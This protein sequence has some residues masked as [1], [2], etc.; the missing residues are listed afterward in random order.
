MAS[1]LTSEIFTN[2]K[3]FSKLFTTS[4]VVKLLSRIKGAETI[5]LYNSNTTDRVPS[6]ETAITLGIFSTF[7]FGSPGL[8]RSGQSAKPKFLP[9][10]IPRFSMNGI[11]LL[12]ISPGARLLSIT[13][14]FPSSKFSR[15]VSIA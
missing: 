2:L 13:S 3:A 5:D 14:I 4:A 7:Q 12:V 11:I 1:S 6:S 8:I 15:K 10:F 9:T